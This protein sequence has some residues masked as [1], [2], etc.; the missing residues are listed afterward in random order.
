[1]LGPTFNPQPILHL[2]CSPPETNDFHANHPPASPNAREIFRHAM[3]FANAD[4]FLR[5]SAPKEMLPHFDLA[6]IVVNAS[7]IELFM[8]CII[9][10]DS[11]R[12]ARKALRGHD[13]AELFN[14]ITPARQG[15][16]IDLWNKSADMH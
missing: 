11:L 14:R 9:V 16:I 5:H 10:I 4:N 6:T 15:Q 2:H 13:L 12:T 7:A 1:M 8:K 3:K